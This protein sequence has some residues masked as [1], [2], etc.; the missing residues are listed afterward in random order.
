MSG[1]VCGLAFRGGVAS[2]RRVNAR[3]GVTWCLVLAC[4]RTEVVRL[5]LEPPPVVDA[6][7]ARD[8]GSADA[9][10]D[11]GRLDAGFVP[12]PCIDG[13]FTLSPAE[14]VVMLVLDR[15]GSMD[16]VFSGG[17]TRWSALVSSLRATLPGVDQSMQLGGLAFPPNVADS[18]T[19]PDV[20]GIW[21]SRGNVRQILSNLESIVPGGS[22]PTAEAVRVAAQ[23][24]KGR[25]ASNA[26]RA[27]VLATDGAPSCE[28][29]LEGTLV[30]LRDA[31][32]DG[33]PTWVI[34]IADDP[35][36]DRA[37]RQ[38]AISGGRARATPNEYYPAQSPEQLE[39]AFRTIRD[40]VGAC[41][42][43]TSSV[44][45]ARGTIRVTFD[46]VEVTH[47][48]RGLEGWRWTD[49]ENGELSLV[50]TAC[51]RAVAR[52]ASLVATVACQR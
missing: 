18:C 11:A 24:L 5:P 16:T 34:G 17:V 13:T 1:R 7:L 40:Q 6:G 31:E 45:D 36:L 10:P 43:L 39:L 47:D 50:G 15:S 32:R 30:R 26:A 33:I 29:G 12:R 25:R 27:I 2:G 44:P 49:R 38:M 35:F 46:G 42:F 3:L 20:A 22:T 51:E 48:E 8:A 52:P 19:V 4:G 21:P 41:S 23:I 37:L 28:A 14:P 9:G